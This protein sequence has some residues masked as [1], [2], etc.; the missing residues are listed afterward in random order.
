MM[1]MLFSLA[2]CSWLGIEG[3][4][5]PITTQKTASAI[6]TLVRN[7]PF[8]DQYYDAVTYDPEIAFDPNLLLEPLTHLRIKPGYTLDFVY[9][10]NLDFG[11]GYATVYAHKKT[12]PR[13]ETLESFLAQ[14]GQCDPDLNPAACECTDF[15]ETDG[16]KEGYFEFVLFDIMRHQIYLFGHSEYGEMEVITSKA[17]L[18][19]LA[20]EINNDRDDFYSWGIPFSDGEKKSIRQID[21]VPRVI[22]TEEEVTVRMIYFSRWG[23]FYEVVETITP[24][25]PHTITNI[26]VNNILKYDCGIMF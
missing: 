5:N 23:G 11:A 16:T 4:L 24:N 7:Q 22:I 18:D 15:I 13:F 20:E 12:A 3:R 25:M 17:R 26:D 2:A 6:T 21:P 14:Q 8:P 1:C 10:L 9:H 19:V